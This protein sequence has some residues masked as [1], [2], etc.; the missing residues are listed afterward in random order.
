MSADELLRDVLLWSLVACVAYLVL[1]NVLYVASLAFAAAESVR[2]SRQTR[3]EDYETLA[4]SRFT[5]PVS[6]LVAAFDEEQGI[7]AAVRSMLRL[8]YPEYEVVVVNDGSRDGTLLELVRAFELEPR[9][10]FYRRVLPTQG[11]RGIYRS[12]SEPRLLVVDKLNGGKADALNCGINFARYRYVCGVD[13]DTVLSEDALLKGMRP[14]MKDPAAILGVTAHLGIGF[15]AERSEAARLE[16]RL[17]DLN[18]LS[19]LQH[20]DYVRSFFN[21]RLAWSRL[22]FMLCT[23]GAFHIWRRDLLEEVGGFSVDFTCE[24]IELTFRVHEKHRREGRPYQ[25]LSLPDTV[26]T[27]EGP[28]RIRS[29]ISQRARWQRVILESV[30][31]YRRM[32]AN[33]RYGAVGLVGM[34]F[35]VVS[36]VLAAVFEPLALAL[37]PLGIAAGAFSW[38]QLLLVLGTIAFTNGMLTSAAVLLHD[39][40]ARPYRVR[41]LAR[42]AVLGPLDLFLYRPFLVWARFRGTVDFLRGDKG[43]DK[44]ERNPRAAP[45]P[46]S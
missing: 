32:F 7:V 6:V 16:G 40:S 26:G 41:D 33:R 37:L 43:W 45:A 14:V 39:R 36:E 13:A 46:A 19:N 20:L 10:V 18:P 44:F 9:E 1:L 31:H 11:V 42:L 4:A 34:P 23:V 28:R 2:R 3:A 17:R 21:N 24:D 35:Y 30:W 25:I 15:D 29:L 38:Q 12:A 22:G 27:T 8:D 5:I